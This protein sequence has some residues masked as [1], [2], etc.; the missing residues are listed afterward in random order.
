MCVLLFNS[1]AVWRAR[2]E[3]ESHF[4]FSFQIRTQSCDVRVHLVSLSYAFVFSSY[5][6]CVLFMWVWRLRVNFVSSRAVFVFISYSFHVVS[7]SLLFALVFLESSCQTRI[8]SCGGRVYSV[9]F[10]SGFVFKVVS[11]FCF[12]WCKVWKFRVKFVSTRA[13]FSCS[14]RLCIIYVGSEKFVAK[15]YQVVCVRVFFV[16]FTCVFEFSSYS[17]C[18]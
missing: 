18:V 14:V 11:F 8:Q 6:S 2:T 9:Y 17:A 7:C 16:L 12:I 5:P 10:S 15:S 3:L 1:R 13:V 4:V